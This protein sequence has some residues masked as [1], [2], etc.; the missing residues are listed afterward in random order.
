V[1]RKKRFGY[2]AS[3]IAISH[4]ARKSPSFPLLQRGMKKEFPPFV[5]GGE[6]G[7]ER[8]KRTNEM[9]EADGMEA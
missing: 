5:R 4:K 6:G 9:N 3:E 1:K 8:N 7:F 2:S